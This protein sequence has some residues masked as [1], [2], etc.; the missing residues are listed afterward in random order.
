[1]QGNVISVLS[2]DSRA[3]AGTHRTDIIGLCGGIPSKKLHIAY[4]R[5][6]TITLNLVR[7][8]K[9]TF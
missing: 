9:E 2:N 5:L 8:S 7:L 6:V 1:M 4:R 3:R